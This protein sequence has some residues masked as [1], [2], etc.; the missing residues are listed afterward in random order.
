MGMPEKLLDGTGRCC[1]LASGFG[2]KGVESLTEVE[3]VEELSIKEFYI[4][5]ESKP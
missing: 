2:E 4:F 3:K 5:P 1:A